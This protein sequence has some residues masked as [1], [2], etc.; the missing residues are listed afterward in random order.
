MIRN[1][2]ALRGIACLLVVLYH[3]GGWEV[4]I[5]PRVKVLYPF[6][7]FGYAGVDLFFVLSGF[8]ITRAHLAHLGDRSKLPGYLGK[9]F[10]RIYPP[11][12]VAIALT[13]T[14]SAVVAKQ[15]IAS[16]GDST[17]WLTW[18][19]LAPTAAGCKP[20]AVAWTLS[21]ELMFYFAFAGLFLLPK[22]AAGF[23]PA[24][25]A[26]LVTYAAVTDWKPVW[27]PMQ[28]ATSPFVLEFLAGGLVA[29]APAVR[30]PGLWFVAGVGWAVIA[31]SLLNT[32]SPDE[33]GG[34]IAAR[35]LT[36]G[37]SA[38]M[39]VAAA[40]AADGTFTPP[41][42]LVSL[43]DASYSVYLFHGTLCVS[44]LFLT[45]GMSHRFVPHLGWL[46]VMLTAGVGGGWLL[47]FLVERPLLR[48]WRNKPPAKPH[49]FSGRLPFPRHIP[50]VRSS[51]ISKVATILVKVARSPQ[52]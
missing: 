26:A 27:F 11:F 7:Y 23:I 5:W 18:L 36:F 40:V 21:Y 29:V 15:D 28:M 35:I 10:W 30:R 3:V 19:S 43:G 48:V 16:L 34:I 47:H 12:W 6:R 33:L 14:L 9:R 1:V 17:D 41:R 42:W 51:A 50:T 13:V 52:G 39:I 25:W 49:I 31:G 37:P 46:A 22:R 24:G 44:T 8:I 38:A 4:T 20:L 45:W 32:G 2:Q